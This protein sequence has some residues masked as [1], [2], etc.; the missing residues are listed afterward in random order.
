MKMMERDPIVVVVFVAVT[1]VILRW[2]WLDLKAWQAGKPNVNGIPGAT[3]ASRLMIGIAVMGALFL[4]ALE[5]LGEQWLGVAGEQSEAVVLMLPLWLCAGVVEEVVFRGY[6]VV[7]KRGKAALIG[8]AL[9]FS[10]LFTVAHPFFW[11]FTTEGPWWAFWEGSWAWDFSTK[12]WWSSGIVFANSL[13]FYAVRFMPMNPHHSLL[14][15]IA[16]HVAS[17]A[18][19]FAIKASQGFVV[20]W[21]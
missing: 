2:W 19:V 16:A 14:P 21:W 18:G 1:G 20:G 13:W 6:L 9:G 10:L 8:S 17:N 15:C 12:A 4:L 7:T 11:S 3:S 5:A